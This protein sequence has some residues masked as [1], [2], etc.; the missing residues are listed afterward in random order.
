MYS[1][2]VRGHSITLTAMAEK[3]KQMKLEKKK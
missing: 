1:L 3:M 2:Q